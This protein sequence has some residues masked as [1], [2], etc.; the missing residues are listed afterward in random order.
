MIFGL[1]LIRIAIHVSHP[2]GVLE[3][4]STYF[5]K[6]T[7]TYSSA[8]VKLQEYFLTGHQRHQSLRRLPAMLSLQLRLIGSAAQLADR[9]AGVSRGLAFAR[10]SALP[11]A[12]REPNREWLASRQ[13]AFGTTASSAGRR[14]NA[15]AAGVKADDVVVG[16][17]TK[18]GDMAHAEEAVERKRA[19][20]TH[21]NKATWA[22]LVA[23]WAKEGDMAR[24][25]EVMERMVTAG[26]K[27]S[28]TT[29]TTLVDGWAKKGNMARAER[30]MACTAATG[31]TANAVTW[32]AL[33]NG[34]AKKGDVARA[35]VAAERM[36]AAG[37]TA[38]VATWSALVDGWARM[39]EMPRAE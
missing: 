11:I 4:S 15:H 37:V 24:A 21:I 1:S 35:E 30:A 7:C 20:G 25:E 27:A 23:R 5:T 12:P 9:L 31:V 17:A 19:G 16:D 32:T 33:V 26:V 14:R 36:G 10:R 34:L 22:A 39:G 28:V 38:N 2:R 13:V 3:Y 6:Y 18:K 29:W 8:R